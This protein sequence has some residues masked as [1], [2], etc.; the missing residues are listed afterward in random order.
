MSKKRDYDNWSRDDLV[1]EVE[2]LRKQKTYG[3]VWEKDKTQ[4]IFDY[5]VNWAGEKT[6]EVF[7]PET[8]HKFPVL[9][10]IKSKGIV[11]DKGEEYNILIEGNNYHSLAVLNFTHSKSVDLIV[12]NSAV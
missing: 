10:E 6:K 4:E 7:S 8:Q 12:H 9:K 3:L 2:A 1:R 5:Y 11:T